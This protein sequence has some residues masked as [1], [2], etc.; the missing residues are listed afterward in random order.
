MAA[1]S[2]QDDAVQAMADRAHTVGDHL[3]MQLPDGAILAFGLHWSAIVG[4]RVDFLARKKAREARATHYVH[5]GTGAA[6][7]GCA[8][9]HG[10]GT[11]GPDVRRKACYAAAQVFAGMHAQ[12]AAAGLLRIDQDRTWLVAARDG[13]V[14]ARTDRI[15]PSE[16]AAQAALAELDLL[17]PGVAQDAR[18]LSI[19]DLAGA[20]DP[21]AALWRMGS[22][23]RRVPLPVQGAVLLVA[24][25]LLAPP[26][27]RAWHRSAAAR[28]P[29]NAVDTDQAWQDAL[30]HAAA[31]VHI[32]DALQLGRLFEALRGLPMAVQGWM[33]ESARCQPEDAAWT[34]SARYAR[35]GADATNQTLSQALP[36]SVRPV[37]SSLD[38]A[39]IVWRVPGHRQALQ[40]TALPRA[41][42]TDLVFGSAL[43]TI[44]PAFARIALGP[45]A[46]LPVPPPRDERGTPLPA[47]S[48]LP[49]LQR[50]N[51]V[52]EGP[53]RSFALF[54]HPPATASWTEVSLVLHAQRRPDISHSPLTAQ[55]QGFIYERE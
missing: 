19:H 12:G 2:L 15:Y 5:G 16:A 27:W 22:P 36:R 39:H 13:A 48:D 14:M 46:A 21:A 31:S 43:Q 45:T 29:S 38:E 17:H 53:L 23:L 54:A 42:Q 40:P 44:R 37:F 50:R 9:L 8:R 35:V 26:M 41:S 49:Q 1:V 25:A 18:R 55:L 4:S 11:A 10:R 28:P 47:P 51:V 52:L 24:L 3:L 20:L 34:C 32:H 33:L 7:V 30:A 6:A